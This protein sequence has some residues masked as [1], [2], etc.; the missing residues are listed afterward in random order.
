MPGGACPGWYINREPFLDVI[1][2]HRASVNG[3][4]KA[5]VPASHLRSPANNAGTKP[6]PT[7]K[8]TATE[9]A[10]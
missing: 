5:N 1:R 7:A 6:W 10:K 8:N 4:N 9:I 2:M 3:I